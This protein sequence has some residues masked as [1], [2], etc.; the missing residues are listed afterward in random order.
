MLGTLIRYH[1]KCISR[2][3]SQHIPQRPEEIATDSIISDTRAIGFG[4]YFHCQLFS[5]LRSLVLD[6]YPTITDT[7]FVNT[8]EDNIRERGAMNK[9]ISDRGTYEISNKVKDILQA[10]CIAAWQSEPGHQHQNHAERRMQ[11]VK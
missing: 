9:L 2:H 11:T 3:N 5:G 1:S 4:N 7:Q 6:A 10:Y 8:L